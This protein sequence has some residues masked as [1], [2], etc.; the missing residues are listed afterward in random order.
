MCQ[1]SE[2]EFVC[3]CSKLK[4]MRAWASDRQQ[5]NKYEMKPRCQRRVEIGVKMIGF[6]DTA[7]LVDRE[8]EERQGSD[9]L[10]ILI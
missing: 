6:C 4:Q 9:Y 2:L 7:D 1:M 10:R 3:N 5:E 8:R